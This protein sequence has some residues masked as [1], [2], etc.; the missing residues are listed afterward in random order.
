MISPILARSFTRSPARALAALIAGA[1]VL[2][3]APASAQAA[4][5]APADDY[6]SSISVT[7]TQVDNTKFPKVTM[8]VKVTNPAGQILEGLAPNNFKVVEYNQQGKAYQA[9]INKV[10]RLSKLD[11]LTMDLVLDKSGSMYGSRMTDAKAAALDFTNAISALGKN[12]VEVTAFDDS[13]YLLQPFTDNL[14]AVKAA[15][16]SISAYD[17]GNTAIYDA[18]ISALRQTSAQS[19]ARCVIIFTDGMENASSHTESDVVKLAQLTNIPVYIIG[20]GSGVNTYALTSLASK[21]GGQYFS[22]STSNLQSVLTGI[23]NSIYSYQRDLYKVTYTTKFTSATK[24]TRKVQVTAA[25]QNGVSA[26]TTKS[27]MPTADYTCWNG[28]TKKTLKACGN[29]SGLESTK[30]IFPSILLHAAQTTCTKND[31]SKRWDNAKY[32]E[33]VFYGGNPTIR[34]RYWPKASD[35]KKHYKE[36]YSKATYKLYLNG[37]K[38]GVVYWNKKKNTSLGLYQLT[39]VLTGHHYSLS[40][41]AKTVAEQKAALQTVRIRV[42]KA[43]KGYRT[44]TVP[45]E[46]VPEYKK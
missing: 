40:V 12:R 43:W 15:I 36:K 39:I 29:P 24:V 31:G 23:Y 30:Y 8:Y 19:G 2:S 10:Q 6:N 32:Y 25:D 27:Y 9:T 7:V 11:L 26:S 44:G 28:K 5:A 34:Y 41:D 33:C 38:A 16:K 42:L 46:A 17:G 21:A 14:T 37:K 3:L 20:V 4:P 22:A 35:A 45:A 1:L 18:I 13:V